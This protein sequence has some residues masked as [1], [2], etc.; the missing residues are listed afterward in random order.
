MIGVLHVI[1][2]PDLGTQIRLEAG[3]ALTIGRGQQND[4]KLKDP[5]VSRQHARVEMTAVDVILE[6][7]G[8]TAGVFV[9]N[10]KITRVELRNGD[11]VSLGTTTQFRFDSALDQET[12]TVNVVPGSKQHPAVT[13]EDLNLV[14]TQLAHFKIDKLIARGQSSVVFKA[15][16]TRDNRIVALKV[17]PGQAQDEEDIQRFV[18]AMKTMMPLRHPNL[19]QILHAGRTTSYCWVAMEYVEGESLTEVIRRIGIAG[20]LDWRISLRVAIHIAR[21]LKFAQEHHIIHRNVT[22]TN[23]MLRTSDKV[24]LLGD[25]MLAKAIE[26]SLAQKVTRQGELLG[27]LAYMAPERTRGDDSEVDGRSDIYGLGATVYALLTGRPPFEGKTLTETIMKI[28]NEAPVKP[29]KYQITIPDLFADM[30]MRTLAKKPEDR[31]QTAEDFLFDLERIAK[32]QSV[33]V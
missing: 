4:I 30:V 9:N 23:I 3:K 1:A 25:L 27:N 22:P 6:D 19:I 20:M 26:G 28:R 2:G 29:K 10:N 13:N 11:V 7:T 21:A 14:G 33:Q 18:R 8:S 24:A 15:T 32:Y 17:L 31:Y 16:D 12:A 5:Q